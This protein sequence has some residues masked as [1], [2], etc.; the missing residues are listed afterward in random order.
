[1]IKPLRIE[2]IKY[3]AHRLAMDTMGWDEP[4]PEF[5]TRYPNVLE[6]CIATPFQ[7][8]AQRT[9]YA[10]LTGKG[11]AL[12]YLLIKNHPFQNGNKRLA[13]A[14]LF[15]FLYK[16]DKWLKVD[17]K[18]L[19]NLAIWVAQSPPLARDQVLIVVTN[20]IKKYLNNF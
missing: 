20:F 11:S 8:F 15:I 14:S 17:N 18:E 13:I 1:M 6:S 3:L 7:R 5:E 2:E 19:Y 12:F 10:G 4:I 9:L 16:N